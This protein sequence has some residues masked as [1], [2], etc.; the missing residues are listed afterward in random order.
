MKWWDWSDP[1]FTFAFITI[2]ISFLSFIATVII[3]VLLRRLEEKSS[4][5]Q[6]ILDS[7][8]RLTRSQRIDYLT[9]R[10]KES[11]D[12]QELAHL[13]EEVEEW[14]E[15]PDKDDLARLYCNNLYTPLHKYSSFFLRNYLALIMKK[16]VKRFRIKQNGHEDDL[17]YFIERLKRENLD[18]PYGSFAE[19]YTDP[20]SALCLDKGEGLQFYR[21]LVRSIPELSSYLI[22]YAGLPVLKDFQ[23]GGF[24]ANVLTGVLL[25][26]LENIA[27]DNMKSDSPKGYKYT[28]LSSLANGMHGG[29]L[30]YGLGEWDNSRYSDTI[31][32]L[33]ALIVETLG[34]V[35][36]T[37]SQ[38]EQHLMMRSIQILPSIL[39]QIHQQALKDDPSIKPEWGLDDERVYRGVEALKINQPALW[40]QYG[41]DIETE[42]DKMGTSWRNP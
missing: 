33:A 31:T 8:E 14:P 38:D 42:L 18:V 28:L 41:Q 7:L 1:A 9:K 35:S 34:S 22:G 21:E 39:S 23:Y 6:K 27:N 5:N 24:K 20:E 17:K 40:K 37:S 2:V 13:G 15:G 29:G 4:K 3:P 12:A 19:V 30:F 10:L 36:K 32:W 25:G 16:F 26:S 11:Q